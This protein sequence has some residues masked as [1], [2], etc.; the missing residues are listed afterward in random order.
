MEM[1]KIIKFL[2]IGAMLLSMSACQEADSSHPNDY[3][4][5]DSSEV[6]SEYVRDLYDEGETIYF[7]ND[8]TLE[9]VSDLLDD[10]FSSVPS[11]IYDMEGEFIEYK[12]MGIDETLEYD[13]IGVAKDKAIYVA[14]VPE[15]DKT[16][17]KL[18]NGLIQKNEE[19]ETNSGYTIVSA[20]SKG[21]EAILD[22]QLYKDTGE[23]DVNYDYYIVKTSVSVEQLANGLYIEHKKHYSEDNLVEYGP[24]SS[25]N[26]ESISFSVGF[27]TLPFSMTFSSAPI[28]EVKPSF[29]HDYI[30]WNVTKSDLSEKIHTVSTWASSVSHDGFMIDIA[31]YGDFDNRLLSKEHTEETNITI[32]VK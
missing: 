30:R 27:N 21:N 17:L 3:N 25:T 9:Q 4:I 10:D 5:F 19:R 23:E 32:V 28:I 6:G 20:D 11:P 24:S 8:V 12:M 26:L 15:K 31:F 1:N 18:I 7:Y 29:S 13:I 2:L 14:K 16:N 22:Y